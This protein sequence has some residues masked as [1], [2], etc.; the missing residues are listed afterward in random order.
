MKKSDLLSQ[1]KKRKGAGK[2]VSKIQPRPEDAT[3]RPSAGQRRLF[4]LQQLYP[5]NR[6]YQYGHRYE[7]NGP[8]QES[9]LQESFNWVMNRHEALRA[10]FSSV[11]GEVVL[12]L[13]DPSEVTLESISLEEL[14]PA[15][16][17]SVAAREEAT[18]LARPFDLEDGRLIKGLLIRFSATSHRLILSMHHIIGDRGAL[19]VFEA[20]LFDRYG[21]CLSGKKEETALAIQYPDFAHWE[22][23]RTVKEE[24]YDYWRNQLAGELPITALPYDKPRPAAVSFR[25]KTLRKSL[26]ATTADALRNLAREHGTTLNTVVLAVYNAFLYRYTGQQDTLIGSPVSTRDRTELEYLV[27]FFNET[28]V[29]RQLVDPEATF[30]QLIEA[31]RPTL[32]IALTHKDVPFDWLVNALQPDRRGGLNPFFQT[33]YV[34][35]AQAPQ[36]QL[37]AGLSVTDTM[38]DLATAKFDLTLFATDFGQGNPLELS[39]EYATDLFAEDTVEAMLRHLNVLATSLATSPDRRV[40]YATLLEAA[41]KQL[42]LKDWNHSF[43]TQLEEGIEPELLPALVQKNAAQHARSVAVTDGS[44]AYS[45]QHLYAL[46]TTLAHKLQQSGLTQGTAV[47]LYCGRTPDLLVGIVGIHLA[48]GAYVPLDPEY[49]QE[50]IDFIVGDCGAP[51]IVH[52]AGLQPPLPEGT[53]AVEIPRQAEDHAGA[54]LPSILPEHPAYLI[55]TSGS[56]GKPKG[57]V[58]NHG[59]LARSTAARFTFYDQQPGVFLLLSSFA[60]DS[61]VAGIFWALASGGTLLLSGRRAEQDPA[62]LGRLIKQEAVTHTLLLP[63]LYQLLLEFAQ[64]KDLA[65]LNTVMVA[66]EAC[67]AALVSQH[68]RTLPTAKLVNEYGPTEGT[69]WST[70]HHLSPEDGKGSVPIGRPIPGMGHYVLDEQLQ[71]VP[72]GVAGE[73]CLSGPQLAAG[74]HGLPEQTEAAFQNNPFV[75][76]QRLY[77]TGDL[78]R[79]RRDGVIDFLGRRDQQVKIRGHRIELTEISNVLD[80][81][82]GIRESVVTV[83]ERNGELS[84]VA[85]CEGEA[86]AVA[87]AREAL[88]QQLPAYMVPGVLMALPEFP[89]LPNGKIDRRALPAPEIAEPSVDNHVSPEG[90]LE[91]QLADLWQQ[92]LKVEAVGRHDN[93]FAI[94]GDSLKSIRIIAGAKKLGLEVAPHHLFNHQT[95]AELATALTPKKQNSASRDRGNY[96][97]A[98]LLRKGG[99]KPPLFCLHS[100]GGHVFFYQALAQKVDNSRS[101]Y[102]VQP[103]GLSGE[104]NLPQSMEEMAANYIAAIKEVQPTGPYLLL[105]TCFSNAVAIEM[106]AQLS[107]AGEPMLPLIIV[108]SGTGN[109]MKPGAELKG[110]TKLH[111]LANLLRAGRWDMIKRKFRN[112]SILGYRKA[113]SQVDEQKRN[114]YGTIA[115]LNSIYD[116]YTWKPYAGKVLLIRS[117][118]FANRRDKDHH[119]KRWQA[120]VGE[121]EVKV[122]EGKHLEMFLEPAVDGLAQTINQCIE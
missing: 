20:Q 110:K 44:S 39:L 15:E 109:F 100:G 47:G 104:S 118:E 26:S 9:Y 69:V 70:A 7:L 87:G 122:T 119:V 12:Q 4:L 93:F 108:D 65:S 53:K 45:W 43:L 1:W 36:R 55:Y 106:A 29:L 22:A 74:Y 52:E 78:V 5:G 42:L 101:V 56:T 85:Y 72:R 76:G 96:E 23:T 11:E 67:P 103:R 84:L 111:S 32:E 25:G 27:G 13:N 21:Q 51:L 98:V 116:A 81:I 73:L 40:G 114:L 99:S 38:I 90:E 58:I 115:G 2:G 63:S 94:G 37:A 95:V 79:Y 41:D 82:A 33:M 71:A 86:G 35:N 121:V 83:V 64:P 19:Q 8:L 30:H 50:R 105:G 66:G 68:H 59:N 31:V 92:V 48:G 112:L 117:T 120:L 113:V 107:A 102:A 24:H 97:A 34:F 6:F 3:A 57:I 60:F 91:Q 18:F 16:Q 28:V 77:R 75:A 17:Q 61:S 88:Q 62:A 49:P 54:T 46:S 14:S 80:R 10:N 89:R